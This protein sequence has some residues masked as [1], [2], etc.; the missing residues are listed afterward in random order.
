MTGGCSVCKILGL[1]DFCSSLKYHS[2]QH[3]NIQG[4]YNCWKYWKSP[5][6]FDSSRKYW[7][8]AGI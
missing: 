4:V 7:K 5:E 1:S 8:S 3:Y 6:I 2:A